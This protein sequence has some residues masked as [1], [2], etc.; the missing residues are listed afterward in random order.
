VFEYVL[1]LIA[2]PTV[3]FIRCA[4][5]I[6]LIHITLCYTHHIWL[7]LCAYAHNI[8]KIRVS[9]DFHLIYLFFLRTFSIYTS[10]SISI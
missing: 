9:A 10:G 2:C 8:V 5:V 6:S 7:I 1:W 4:G 3:K